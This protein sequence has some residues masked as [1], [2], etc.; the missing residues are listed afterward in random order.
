MK[1]TLS[2]KPKCYESKP[3][4]PFEATGYELFYYAA[5]VEDENG[6]TDVMVTLNRSE[7]WNCSELKGSSA[8]YEFNGLTNSSIG[9]RMLPCPCA[10]CIRGI[11]DACSNVRIVGD[12]KY[13]EMKHIAEVDVPDT[14]SMPLTSYTIAILKAF[15]KHHNIKLP[16]KQNKVDLISCITSS[17]GDFVLENENEENNP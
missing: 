11:Y 6:K 15:L 10:E 3:K 12:M 16:R 7:M 13:Q 5:N 2:F 9:M 4:P 17:L 14:L 1:T 8:C